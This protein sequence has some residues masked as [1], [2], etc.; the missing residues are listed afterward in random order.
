MTKKIK[1]VRHLFLSDRT[2][3]KLY[4][5]DKF[6]C[7]TLEDK[8]RFISS[9]MPLAII[10]GIKVFGRTAIPVGTYTAL[11]R[12]MFNADKWHYMLLKVKGFEGIFIHAGNIPE[13]TKG[14]ILL[15]DR[16]L[17]NNN[18]YNSRDRVNQFEILMQGFPIEIEIIED[19]EKRKSI[20]GLLIWLFM[21]Y[22]VVMFKTCLIWKN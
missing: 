7:D 19:T 20:I 18:I 1:L 2:L 6:F 3:G 16:H 22:L 12:Y 21:F 9:K 14:C 15:G 10:K 4:I 8:S 13:H 11:N 17:I 5:D